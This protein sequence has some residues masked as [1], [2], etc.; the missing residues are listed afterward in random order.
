[1]N[2]YIQIENNQPINHPAFEENLLQAFG[3]IPAH[4]EPF[5]R[6]ERPLPTLYQMFDSE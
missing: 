3:A 1:M 5:V 6:V 2:L 4:W